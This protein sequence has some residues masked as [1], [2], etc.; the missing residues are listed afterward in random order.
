MSDY[1]NV[2]QL[3]QNSSGVGLRNND[4]SREGIE[5]F[6]RRNPNTNFVAEEDGRIIGAILS[7]HDGRRGYIYH[8]CIADS[9][10]RRGIGRQLVD[11]VIGAMKDE[12]ITALSLFCFADNEAGNNFWSGLGWI[13]RPDLNTYRFYLNE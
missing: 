4:D 3:W 13:K 10:R 2:Y 12:K 9:H 7:G 8:M 11:K 6:V 1:D 5:R